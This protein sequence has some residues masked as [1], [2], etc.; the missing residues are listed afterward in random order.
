MTTDTGHPTRRSSLDVTRTVAVVLSVILLSCGSVRA[1]VLVDRERADTYFYDVDNDPILWNPDNNRHGPD[2]SIPDV[3]WKAEADQRIDRFRKRDISLTV[4]DADGNPVAGLPIRFGLKRH[5]FPFGAVTTWGFGAGPNGDLSKQYLL[6]Y[7]NAAGF[8]MGMKPTQCES[9]ADND[10][11]PYR[12]RQIAEQDLAWL[13]EHDFYVRGHTLVWDGQRF[14]HP[15]LKAIAADE[16]LTDYEKGTEIAD[17]MLKRIHHAIDK[18]DVA[19]WDVVNEPRVNHLV[20]EMLPRRDTMVEAFREADEARRAHGRDHVRLYYNENQI[21]SWSRWGSYESNRDVYRRR[22]DDLIEA[23][24]PID[25]IGFQYRFK[26]P[27][28]PEVVWDRMADFASYGLPYQA[29]EFEL[30]EAARQPHAWTDRERKQMTAEMITIFFSH[31]LAQ[32]L[33]HWAY[34]DRDPSVEAG[35]RA[36]RRAPLISWEG[37]PTAEFEQW[38]KMMEVDFKTDATLITDEDGQAKVRGFKGTYLVTIGT[39]PRATE[40]VFVLDDDVEITHE[41]ET[42]SIA[43]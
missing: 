5:A 27:A 14:L 41:L 17:R 43:P 7:M 38:I 13:S 3:P 18:W 33:W 31:P 30:V 9:L 12:F 1:S 42:A 39:A 23:G 6:K 11:R 4:T 25:G 2:Y 28:S 20:D 32:G 16:S 34:N 10:G 22:I 35:P 15:N 19:A 37:E 21:F 26:E 24:A 8:G 36:E 40:Y 29:T